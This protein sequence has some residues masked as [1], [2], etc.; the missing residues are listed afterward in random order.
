MIV[1][2]RRRFGL[3][4]GHANDIHLHRYFML[5]SYIFNYIAQNRSF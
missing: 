5:I 4:I 2:G 3:R 1:G